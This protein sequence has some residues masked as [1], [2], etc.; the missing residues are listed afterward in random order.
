MTAT[1]TTSRKRSFST[2]RARRATASASTKLT[3]KFSEPMMA[4][5]SIAGKRSGFENAAPP[6]AQTASVSAPGRERD[7][8]HVE[9]QAEELAHDGRH[10]E[11]EAERHVAAEAGDVARED[12]REKSHRAPADVAA[13][14][15]LGDGF[16]QPAIDGPVLEPAGG[17]ARHPEQHARE[18]REKDGAALRRVQRM[19]HVLARSSS[20]RKCAPVRA[21]Q[22][23]RKR[24]PPGSPGR[25][26]RSRRRAASA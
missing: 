2:P 23:R 8:P 19:Q 10:A 4:M 25:C 24:T 16:G 3:P 6:S 9:R 12:A 22:K 5:P 11:Q 13:E 14:A 17:D 20:S 15:M 21:C 7:V 26:C 18:R 1:E